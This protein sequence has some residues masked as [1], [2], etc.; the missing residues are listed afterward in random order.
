ME[1]ESEDK[2]TNN[3]SENLN[4]DDKEKISFYLKLGKSKKFKFM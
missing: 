4:K 1:S 2:A 3:Q